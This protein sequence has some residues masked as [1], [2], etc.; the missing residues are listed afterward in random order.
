MPKILIIDDDPDITRAM[1]IVLQKKDHKV[2]IS[3]SGQEGIKKVDKEN[4]DLEMLKGIAQNH[5]NYFKE[6]N[7]C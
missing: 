6:V 7:Q 1:E 3:H 2:I 5:V 4:P